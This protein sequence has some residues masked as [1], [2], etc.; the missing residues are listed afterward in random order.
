[1]LQQRTLIKK[2]FYN[3]QEQTM[4]HT[5]SYEVNTVLCDFNVQ[6]GSENVQDLVGDNDLGMEKESDDKLTQCAQIQNIIIR[7]TWFIR[8]IQ[9]DRLHGATQT[10]RYPN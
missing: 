5:N 1:M 7:N 6:V 4:S 9:G 8:H 10:R 3:D 2:V